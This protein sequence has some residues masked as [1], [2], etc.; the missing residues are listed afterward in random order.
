MSDELLFFAEAL[1]GITKGVSSG[2]QAKREQK[3]LEH[4]A[5]T[6]QT[7]ESADIAIK[8][9]ELDIKRQQLDIERFKAR[10]TL[11]KLQLETLKSQRNE[12]VKLLN[13]REQ[14]LSIVGVN[15]PTDPET[16]PTL[17]AQRK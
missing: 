4:E 1:R 12:T 14:D 11:T 13:R 8:G 5:Q 10:D 16:D 17:A 9:A 15:T 7:K 6:R 2:L 3:A